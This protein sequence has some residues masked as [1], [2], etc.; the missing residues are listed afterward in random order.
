M[1]VDVVCCS[2]ARAQEPEPEVVSKG[3]PPP[4]KKKALSAAK[5]AKKEAEMVRQ[6]EAEAKQRVSDP[7][8]ALAHKQAQL[9]LQ[10]DAGQKDIESLF[11]G[12]T[13]G[14]DGPKREKRANPDPLK[15]LELK[16]AAHFDL[17]ATDVAKK[18]L[19][20]DQDKARTPTRH[21]LTGT[22][23]HSEHSEAQRS[24]RLRRPTRFDVHAHSTQLFLCSATAGSRAGP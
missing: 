15:T 17:F 14:D 8:A 24:A 23:R 4:V 16:T 10:E 22:A 5:L 1:C 9:K 6:A 7:K 19:P 11:G 18:V 21:T 20:T 2:G 13:V 12:P 3:P